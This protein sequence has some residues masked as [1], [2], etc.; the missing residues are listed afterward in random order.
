M[1]TV[2]TNNEE[3]IN[4]VIVDGVSVLVSE[5]VSSGITITKEDLINE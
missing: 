1:R 2:K 3:D 5:L 4:I